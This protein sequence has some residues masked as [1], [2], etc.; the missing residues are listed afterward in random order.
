MAEGQ[1]TRID[2]VTVAAL[3]AVAFIVSTVCHE[4]LGHGGTCLAVGDH[5]LD[6]GAYYVKCDR[7]NGPAWTS[8]A[9]A[10][11][12]STVNL[13]LMAVF[14]LLLKARLSSAAPRG[15]GSVFLW[16]MF[17]LNGLTW[18]G[19]FLFSGVA[20]IGDWGTGD[21]AVLQG[22]PNALI[23]RAVMAV[24]GGGLY[25]LIGRAAGRLL[26]SVAGSQ[27][28]GRTVSWTAY[29]TGGL[30]AIPVGFL[31]PL[32]LYVLLASAVASSWGGA[33]GLLWCGRFT[34]DDEVV[35]L[36]VSRN[37]PWIAAGLAIIAAYALVLGPTIHFGGSD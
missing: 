22:V 7:G 31:N 9:I 25:F 35:T 23:W 37:W 6:L 5:I 16:L 17:A 36:S 3:S 4:A 27:K 19:Y 2:L 18:A 20:G 15:S 11:A 8:Q 14:Y 33:S 29:F 34:R 1:P 26:G 10:A 21:G 24:V 13:I 28:T 12:G 30:I 32:G